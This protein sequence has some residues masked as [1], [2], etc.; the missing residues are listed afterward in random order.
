VIT[1]SSGDEVVAPMTRATPE[2]KAA[3]RAAIG[4]IYDDGG[5]CIS[6]GLTRGAAELDQ[7]P[8]ERALRGVAA[9][10]A[11]D[12]LGQAVLELT[13]LALIAHLCPPEPR[14][15]PWA[16]ASADCRCL[17]LG[18][19]IPARLASSRAARAATARRPLKTRKKAANSG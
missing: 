6:C 9:Q 17:T 14:K 4:R 10:P 2:A 11:I 15:A 19:A 8:E 18:N 3:A 5:T 12:L 1:Y 16:S 7:P 13:P